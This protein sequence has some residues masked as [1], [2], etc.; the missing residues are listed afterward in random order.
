MVLSLLNT[1]AERFPIA[2]ISLMQADLM[3][4][5]SGAR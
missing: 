3:A 1:A 5:S 2:L 4:A